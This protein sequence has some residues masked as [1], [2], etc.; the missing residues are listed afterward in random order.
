[1]GLFSGKKEEAK[2]RMYEATET[3]MEKPREAQEET[4]RREEE[5]GLTDRDKYEGDLAGQVPGDKDE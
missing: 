4:W 5:M 1:M 3:A 2:E